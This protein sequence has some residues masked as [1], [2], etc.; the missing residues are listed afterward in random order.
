MIRILSLHLTLLAFLV[1]R[2]PDA[3]FRAQF[4]AEDGAIFFADQLRAGFWHA[5]LTPYSGYLHVIPRILAAVFSGLRV[6]AVP[7]AYG[8]S[9]IVIAAFCCGAFSWPRFRCL[10][11]SDLLRA[12]CCLLM[13][14][15]PT[16]SELIGSITNLQWFLAPLAILI[17]FSSTEAGQR[18]PETIATLFL[19]LLIGLSTPGLFV[20][21]PLF[22]WRIAAQ[23]GWTRWNSLIL[24]A[25]LGVEVLEVW[26]TKAGGSQQHWNF[27][28]VLIS[29]VAGGIAKCV[30]APLLGGPFLLQQ[31]ARS[32]IA[33]M[34]LALL[35]GLTLLC[36]FWMALPTWRQRFV[37]LAATYMGVA[38]VAVVMGGRN[39][40]EAFLVP[41]EIP[42]IQ[43]ERY[44]FLGCCVFI[45]LSALA[46]DFAM[47]RIRHP[48][49]NKLPALALLLVF[50]F[51]LV[52]NFPTPPM[53]DFQ[54]PAHSAEI[55]KWNELRRSGQAVAPLQVPLNP[56]P[57][58]MT[59]QPRN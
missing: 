32:F 53:V 50:A 5:V 14:A 46:T 21:L 17:A 45:F 19:L 51:G 2:R 29:T 31:S 42:H 4:W 55:E 25:G 11:A 33:A 13:A 1:A 48:W 58:R 37:V 6:Q 40:A 18:K 7:A 43:G 41:K 15:M 47:A 49:L 20:V 8:I 56:P 59:L 57:F 28:A 9:S 30:L 39:L 22:L 52:Q 10:I 23:R 24:A 34:L 16:G 3:V 54:W 26:H 44:F 12:L 35:I 36:L 38:S 27:N